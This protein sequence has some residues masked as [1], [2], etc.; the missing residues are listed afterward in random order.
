VTATKLE[1]H[2]AILDLVRTEPVHTQQ[3]LADALARRG[4]AATQATVSRDIQELG[5][6]RAPGGYGVAAGSIAEHVRDVRCVQFLAVVRTAPGTAGLVARRIDEAGPEGVAGTVAGDDT[7][8][9][10]LAD[11]A[12]YPRLLT[13][14]G[15]S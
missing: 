5:L 6:V 4:L 7:L 9:A 8:I 10:V 1:R 3:E 15:V 2:R 11:T 13:L 12:A 14:L